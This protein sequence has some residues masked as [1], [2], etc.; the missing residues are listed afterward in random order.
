MFLTKTNFKIYNIIFCLLLKLVKLN[1]IIY[2]IA[3]IN[4]LALLSMINY[5]NLKI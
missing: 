5:I 1:N 4:F 2:K 3:S